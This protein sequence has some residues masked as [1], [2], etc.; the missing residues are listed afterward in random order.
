[1]RRTT[2]PVSYLRA[3]EERPFDFDFYQVLRRIESFNPGRPRIGR[4]VRPVDEPVRLGQETS[5]SFA[6][7]PLAAYIPAA[8]G[9]PPRLQQR[10]FG[11]LGPN[12]P[13]PLHLTD[14]ARERILHGGDPTMARFLDVLNHR[15]LALLYRAWA[16]AQPT[17]SLDRPADDRFVAYVG[18]LAGVGTG[19]TTKRDAVGDYAKL[20][21]SG[22]L[23]RQV[24]NR[25]GLAAWLAGFF[26][27]PVRVE[28]FVGHWMRLPE[29]DRTRIGVDTE[30][31]RLG[32]GAVAGARVWDRQHKIRIELGPLDL[33]RYESFLPGGSAIGRLVALV[34]QYLCLELEWDARLKLQR[35]QVPR[36]RLGRY[37]R[38]GW[39]TWLGT[40]RREEDAA[41]LT[42]DAERLVS[43]GRGV[44]ASY[45]ETAA[46]M[47][48]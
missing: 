24:R 9:R 1:M 41:D 36:T 46:G 22:L 5:M 16:Q 23:V 13:L 38:L 11:L 34:R 17:V 31:A 30:G 4:A 45:D 37:G 29:Q 28:Q 10:F 44:R 43:A 3:L 40:Y 25:D 26:R 8:E 18:S 6:P 35:E 21:Y 12:G 7:A 19:A 32:V 39:T 14:F 27:V 42:L 2:D 47:A 33:A 20:F 48:A 15:F